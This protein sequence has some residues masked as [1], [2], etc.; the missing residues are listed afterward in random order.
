MGTF[1]SRMRANFQFTDKN[2]NWNEI[3]HVSRTIMQY[4]RNT[5]IASRW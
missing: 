5:A 4:R 3:C 1:V 2:V